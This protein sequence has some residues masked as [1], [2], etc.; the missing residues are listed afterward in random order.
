RR[1]APTGR[2]G[3]PQRRAPAEPPEPGAGARVGGR[4]VVGAPLGAGGMGVVYAA[5]DPVIGREVALKLLHVEDERAAERFLREARAASRL[6]SRH[7]VAVHDF[8]RDPVHGVFIVMERLEGETLADRL[9]R[10]GRLPV[11]EAARIGADIAEALAEAHRSQVVHRD[12]KPENVFLSPPPGPGAREGVKV[13]DFGIAR[14][15]EA[16]E[17]AA[18]GTTEGG[19]ILGTPLY[20]SPEAA[21]GAPVGPAADL[22]ALGVLLFEA[23]SGAPPF[24]D[25]AP[26]ALCAMHLKAR[27]PRLR[28][29]APEAPEALDALVARLLAK[30]PA[31]RGDAPGV[32]AALRALES[33][34]ETAGAAS[35]GPASERA[36]PTVALPVRPRR[37]WPARAGLAALAALAFGLGAWA[38]ATDDEMGVEGRAEQGRAREAIHAA[39]SAP[40]AERVDRARL[41]EASEGR[42]EPRAPGPTRGPTAQPSSDRRADSPAPAR[43]RP[44]PGPAT[45]RIEVRTVPAGAALSWDGE[46]VESPFEVPR[47]EAPHRLVARA[48]G[49]RRAAREV[50]ADRDRSLTLRLRR[51]RRRPRERLPAEL[52]SW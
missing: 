38:L 23:V 9:L 21:R 41:R 42:S 39:S 31:A 43:E 37:R 6:S 24:V 14:I 12:L 8:G 47:D 2:P 36:V 29:R 48:R 1:S 13:L 35:A 46:R 3:A 30:D 7:A 19:R 50:V 51:V 5:E 27:P 34:A 49:G 45:V 40:P 20:I 17:E 26:V 44:L 25:E 10:R 11:G 32:A 18:P 15:L 16:G 22:Y 52:R 33:A 4:F 28:E